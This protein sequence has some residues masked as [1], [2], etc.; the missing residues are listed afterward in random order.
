MNKEKIMCCF[1]G[2]DEKDCKIEA[3]YMI[4][5]GNGPD[6]VTES[7]ACHIGELV[8]DRVE[9]FEVIRISGGIM[10]GDTVKVKAALRGAP[11]EFYKIVRGKNRNLILDDVMGTD[12]MEINPKAIQKVEECSIC[13]GEGAT[14][15]H[16]DP[17]T[18]C[19]GKGYIE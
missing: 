16:H 15:D 13:H 5:Y 17:C 18:N 10:E 2:K 3:E 19:G 1:I 4:I 12:L 9:R 11:D 8:D 6:D 14:T 7:C